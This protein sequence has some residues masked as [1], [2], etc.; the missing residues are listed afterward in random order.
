MRE[1]LW[2]ALLANFET[3]DWGEMVD[4]NNRLALKWQSR[5]SFVVRIRRAV[6]FIMI[7]LDPARHDLSVR[8]LFRVGGMLPVRGGH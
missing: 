1:G 8:K 4:V 2:D 6:A 5:H 3:S 7:G